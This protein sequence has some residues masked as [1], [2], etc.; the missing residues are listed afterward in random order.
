MD[1]IGR[2]TSTYDGLSLAQA[3]LEYLHSDLQ[4]KC[5][6]QRITMNLLHWKK[7]SP[8]SKILPSLTGKG[9][10]VIFL[11]KIIPGKADKSYGVN[12]ARLAGLP[13]KI[14]KRASH[15]LNNLEKSQ[16]PGLKFYEEKGDISSGAFSYTNLG[17]AEGQLSFCRILK[18]TFL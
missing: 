14:I 8:A 4:A 15:I 5:C 12:V 16:A 2:G 6:F 9:E 1:E 17:A 13:G 10:D 11:R 3:I 7:N 18:R